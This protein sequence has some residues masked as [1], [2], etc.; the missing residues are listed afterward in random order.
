MEKLFFKVVPIPK[1]RAVRLS[2]RD[3]HISERT[4]RREKKKEEDLRKL[5]AEKEKKAEEKRLKLV[6]KL[7]VNLIHSIID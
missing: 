4:L 7:I 2:E 1:P 3:I 5:A 6:S